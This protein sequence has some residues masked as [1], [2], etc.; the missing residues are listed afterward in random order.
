MF[1]RP[2]EYGSSKAR[3][4]NVEVPAGSF[5]VCC[6]QPNG[7][8]GWASGAFVQSAPVL[9][10][11]PTPPALP[12]SQAG[13]QGLHMTRIQPYAVGRAFFPDHASLKMDELPAGF[14]AEYPIYLE[15]KYGGL[16]SPCRRLTHY[17]HRAQRGGANLRLGSR[18]TIGFACKA[19]G[20]GVNPSYG[21][22]ERYAPNLYAAG[23]TTAIP[24]NYTAYSE[25]VDGYAKGHMSGGGNKARFFNVEVPTGDFT[26]CCAQPNGNVGWTSGAFVQ[27]APNL[28]PAPT[29]PSIPDFQAISQ[30]PLMTRVAPY[31][32]GQ[33]FFSNIHGTGSDWRMTNLPEGFEE[34]F[35]VYLEAQYG[36]YGGVGNPC[37]RITGERGG[38]NVYV[39]V[40]S[41]IGFA[42]QAAGRGADP[43]YGHTQRYAPFLFKAGETGGIRPE[44]TAY[45]EDIDGYAKAYGQTHT[46]A[47][48]FKV[49]V[50]T[51][52]YT[53]CCQ[54][55][56]GHFGW[57]SGAFVQSAPVLSDG[58]LFNLKE[59]TWG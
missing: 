58:E 35:P 30:G 39:E 36:Q 42:C 26:V 4:F 8:V 6:A 23:S 9:A 57:A 59:F 24:A 25:D 5:T 41:T 40:K 28:T 12:D 21:H 3:F 45:S 47:R 38:A 32:V 2:K 51:G 44:Y 13:S 10:P 54:S 52:M 18:S 29:P 31:T 16:D 34:E 17:D 7:N 33:K 1:A 43:S 19:M 56:S 53:M 50:P 14:Q 55:S 37:R 22:T 15:P 48:F 49:E 20:R 11:A 46:N 27:S